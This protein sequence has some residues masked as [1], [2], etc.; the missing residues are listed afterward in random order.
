MGL[1]IVI[2]TVL[3]FATTVLLIAL[4]LRWDW[5]GAL[6]GRPTDWHHTH[7]PVPRLG[8]ALLAL[9]FIALEVYIAVFHP[10]LRAG[11]PGRDVIV[12][13]SLAMFILGFW[14]DVRPLKASWKLVGQSVIAA[15]VCFCGVGIEVWRIPFAASPTHL[16]A[17]GPVVT[18]VWL[19]SLTNLINLIDGIDGLAGGICL[20]LMVLIAAV[21][22]QNGNFELLASGMAGALLGFLCYNFPPARIYL[23]DGGAY[24]LGFQIGLYSIVNSHKGTVFAALVAP[25]FVLALPV[26]D[27]CLTVAR[28]GLRGLPLFR[29]DRKH[30]HHRLIALG[31]SRRKIVLLVYGVNLLFLFM[32]LLAFWSRGEFVPVL[33]GAAVLVLFA[34][35]GSF[36]FSRR[37]F[38]V[39]RVVRSSLR[40]RGEVQYALSLARWLELEG[41]RRCSGPDEL[42]SDLVFAAEKLGF[43]SLKVTMLD[44]HRLWRRREGDL[45]SLQ[46]RYECTSGQPGS[47]EFTAPACPVNRSAHDP[48]T[49]CDASCS[50]ALGGCLAD[51]RVFETVS[52]LMAEA[53]NVSVTRWNRDERRLGLKGGT[54]RP[55]APATPRKDELVRVPD[56]NGDSPL[57]YNAKGFIQFM[58]RFVTTWI[59]FLI[60][61]PCLHAQTIAPVG[62]RARLSHVPSAE[63][64]LVAAGLVKQAKTGDRSV[65][66]THVVFAAV[67]VNPAATPLIVGAVVRAVP[68][69]TVVTVRVATIEQPK[70]VEEITRAA[71]AIAPAR[72]GSIVNAVCSVVPTR[73]KDVALVAGG[74]APQA[75]REILMAVADARPELKP[76]LEYEIT[77]CGRTMPSVGHCLERAERATRDANHLV[78]RGGPSDGGLSDSVKPD[79]VGPKPPHGNGHPHGGRNYARP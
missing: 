37:W 33:L 27:A 59:A 65:M 6:P 18:I 44:E 62:I 16:G 69:T 19:V 25:L 3:G 21:G 66:T 74:L 12:A 41:R 22:H 40:M 67:T 50:K 35:A 30:L 64:P 1:A 26:S 77:A 52:E 34:C 20:M 51:P 23:G 9:T 38:A 24:F 11:T 8:G 63:L 2:A 5:A 78:E 43:A 47:L 60:G 70:Q 29:P 4:A 14:D 7:E 58:K 39:H 49:D 56:Q 36:G 31:G 73:Y 48:F 13:G 53:W 75:A 71:V 42:W 54:A 46:R 61:V 72:A 17:W 68:E 57:R 10:V 79:A 28:R 15:T 45:G 32:G 55:K 76:Y